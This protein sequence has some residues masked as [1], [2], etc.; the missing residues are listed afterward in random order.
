MFEISISQLI[1]SVFIGI[2]AGLGVKYFLLNR[3]K[4]RN[5]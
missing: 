2:V 4:N 5:K 1:G 3:S